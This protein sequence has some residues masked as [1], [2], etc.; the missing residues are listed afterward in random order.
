MSL[1]DRGAPI[2]QLQ[3]PPEDDVTARGQ[4][5]Q[6]LVAFLEEQYARYNRRELAAG[7]PVSFLYRYQDPLDR[8]VAGLMAALLAYGRLA[9]IVRAVA[10]MLG[11]L[12][13]EPRRFLLG[14]G[15][16]HLERACR[17]FVHRRWDASSMCRLLAGT[18][19]ILRESGSLEAAFRVNVSPDDRSVVRALEGFVAQLS[20]SPSG[21]GHLLPTPRRGSACKRLF[22]FLRWMVRRDEVDPGGWS[23]VR[24]AQLVVPLDVHMHRVCTALG[25]TRRRQADLRAALEIT[26][27]FRCLRPDDPVRY[28][29]ALMHLSAERGMAA[30]NVA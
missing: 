12:G 2:R 26:D 1:A 16:A 19:R 10:D 8:E 29:F 18:R 24:P 9:T 22:L 25:L 13:D 21:M 30:F 3:P 6:P 17:G 14:A 5:Q 15:D 20:G 28:D 4:A 27:A 7:D 23:C 11:R